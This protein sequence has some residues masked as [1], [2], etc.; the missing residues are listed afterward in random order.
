MS[1]ELF[2]GF[3]RREISPTVCSVP[4]G[5][6]GATEH[7]LSGVI[8]DP[9]YV[10]AVA[11]RGGEE[12]L[13]IL[14]TDLLGVVEK[15]VALYR[16]AISEKTGLPK[17]RIFI[18]ASHTHSGPDPRSEIPAAA[19]YRTEQLIPALCDAAYRALVDLKPA[20]LS[21]GSIE[22]GTPTCRMNFDRH[23]N[24]V[25]KG[26]EDNYTEDDKHFADFTQPQYWKDKEHYSFVEHWEK[27]DP[28]LHIMRFER[29]GADDV[30]L[31]NFA[32]HATF[33]GTARGTLVSS[34]WPGAT[35]Q[36]IEKLFP[37]TKCA[38]LQGCAGNMVPETKIESEGLLGLTTGPSCDHH[39]YASVIAGYARRLL[40]K[41]MKDSE[42][43][44]LS[45]LQE[46]V[47]FPYDHSSDHLLP[48]AQQALEVFDQEGNTPAAREHC[49]SFGFR[50]VYTCVGIRKHAGLPE[51][52]EVEL[53]AIRIGDC[54]IAT[55]PFEPYCSTGEY[56]REHSPFALTIANGY[57][58]GYQSYLPTLSVH[59]DAYE[60][61]QLVYKPG[62]AEA[63]GE[64]LSEML[65]QLI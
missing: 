38:F 37:D 17:D 22:V 29:D 27:Q 55:L 10:N 59:P 44:T 40:K 24:V 3:A 62:T 54:A 16:E 14:S 8:G 18:S 36:R 34:D 13:V 51:T 52:G 9:L 41:G 12:K 1:Q 53:N 47:T 21:Y 64:K 25:E 6:F 19:K 11:I 23:Y 49:Y 42:T 35:V 31:F 2:V 46:I 20:K 30:L 65:K 56:I 28:M 33:V 26:K 57:S 43:A 45:V 4:L 7:R 39:A 61:A 58:C 5:G 32:A 15:C 63:V 60:S 48:K 50:S